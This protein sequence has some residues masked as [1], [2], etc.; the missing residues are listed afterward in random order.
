MRDSVQ[1][2]PR[3]FKE[4]VRFARLRAEKTEIQLLRVLLA[5]VLLDTLSHVQVE[6]VIIAG[7]EERHMLDGKRV[8]QPIANRAQHFVQ[9]C[10]RSQLARKL[11]QRAAVVVAVLIEEIAVQLFLQPVANGLEDERREQNQS[12]DRGRAQIFGAGEREDQ[13]VENPQH[14][15][16]RE[17][18][19]VALLENDIDVH[20]AVAQDGVSPRQRE[21]GSARAP[22]SSGNAPA[23]PRTD[24]APR[25][26]K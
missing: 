25:R 24:M 19:N 10:F 8:H 3:A 5:A 7:Q 4:Q 13:A 2:V 21:A 14:H 9:I 12:D 20:Q 18:V 23:A 1:Q 15:Q 16:R 22:P 26:S 11:D 6:L 17:S